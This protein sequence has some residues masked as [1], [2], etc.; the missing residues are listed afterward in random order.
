MTQAGPPRMLRRPCFLRK[1]RGRAGAAA[2]LA[3]AERWQQAGATPYGAQA[4]VPRWRPSHG[5][6]GGRGCAAGMGTQT[7][8]RDEGAQANVEI[9]GSPAA[10]PPVMTQGPCRSE[11]SRRSA[12]PSGGCPAARPPA[13]P[14]GACRSERSRRSTWPS[15]GCPAA[16]PPAMP[17]GPA[18]P[19]TA[20]AR[21]LRPARRTGRRPYLPPE[22]R[23]NLQS[24]D[25]RFWSGSD[26][27]RTYDTPG[28]N[29]MLWPTELLSHMVA[30][31]GLE[32]TTSGL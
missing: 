32:P 8:R 7:R 22:Q 28:M 5:G 25:C 15:G 21:G 12:R 2:A 29:R 3:D 31:V 14:Q 17:Q 11:R 13:M 23:K 1:G 24:A 9:R 16:R 30:G 19:Y 20:R 18:P 26:R 6:C 4:P 27:I 10:R